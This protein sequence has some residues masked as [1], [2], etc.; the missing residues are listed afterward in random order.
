MYH[1]SV[2]E[3]FI[4]IETALDILMSDLFPFLDTGLTWGFHSSEKLLFV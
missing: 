1:S 2:L 3:T 4:R